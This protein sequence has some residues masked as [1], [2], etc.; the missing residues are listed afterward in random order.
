MAALVLLPAQFVDPDVPNGRTE[1]ILLPSRVGVGP[2]TYVS[3]DFASIYNFLAYPMVVSL[4]V[5]IAIGLIAKIMGL[6]LKS[7]PDIPKD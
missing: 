4:V 3:P 6:P 5:L 1:A 2:T 7:P